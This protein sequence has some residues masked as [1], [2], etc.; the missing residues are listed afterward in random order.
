MAQTVW[1]D[2]TG[3]TSA[4]FTEDFQAGSDSRVLLDDQA[5]L[6]GTDFDFQ[7]S[8]N[9]TLNKLE[10]SDSTGTNLISVTKSGTLELIQ[11]AQL[12]SDII[13]SEDDNVYGGISY[14]NGNIYILEQKLQ[15]LMMTQLEIQHCFQLRL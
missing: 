14:H 2:D 4:S 5:L 9:N 6:L 3:N 7:M 11:Q 1:V 12:P 15:M 10:F 8:Y 13:L